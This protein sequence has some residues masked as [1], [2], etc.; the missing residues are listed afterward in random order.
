VAI[1]EVS[2]LLGTMLARL[3]LPDPNR[4]AEKVRDRREER[5]KETREKERKETREMGW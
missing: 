4:P 5:R 1:K 3:P 2:M